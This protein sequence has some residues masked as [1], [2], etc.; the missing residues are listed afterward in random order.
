MRKI[1]I[2]I[3]EDDPIIAEDL[4]DRLLQMG[5]HVIGLVAKGE[6][7]IAFFQKP[8]PDLV[9][10]DIQLEGEWDGKETARNI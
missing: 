3:V 2:L 1:H 6:E 7:I 8:S 4:E 5:H 10:M 9:L